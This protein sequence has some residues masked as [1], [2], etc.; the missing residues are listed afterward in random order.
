MNTVYTLIKYQIQELDKM[1]NPTDGEFI[2]IWI[3]I[4]QHQHELSSFM[5]T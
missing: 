3:L 1:S 5:N 4:T 2:L